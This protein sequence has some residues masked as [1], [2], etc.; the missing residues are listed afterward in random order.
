MA[1]DS[2]QLMLF[3]PAVWLLNIAVSALC[4]GIFAKG[5]PWRVCGAIGVH[6]ATERVLSVFFRAL[7][8]SRCGANLCLPWRMPLRPRHR[9]PQFKR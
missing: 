3:V 5:R 4:L 9:F 6:A 1:Y 8:L 7:S 2:L